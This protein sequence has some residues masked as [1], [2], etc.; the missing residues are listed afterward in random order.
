MNNLNNY[1]STTKK[2]DNAKTINEC[3]LVK[4]KDYAVS[5]YFFMLIN[6]YFCFNE[7]EF[8]QELHVIRNQELIRLHTYIASL[9]NWFSDHIHNAS[10]CSPAH[11][12]LETCL[13]LISKISII[14]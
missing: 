6:H 5:S 4:E 2:P 1:M 10:Q 12:N 11:R 3:Y 8:L 14:A 13:I 9:I 7:M